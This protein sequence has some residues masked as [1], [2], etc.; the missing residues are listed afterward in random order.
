MPV[1]R[2]CGDPG[3]AGAEEI[4]GHEHIRVAEAK[5]ASGPVNPR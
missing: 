2:K 4:A 5:M 3:M 1:D